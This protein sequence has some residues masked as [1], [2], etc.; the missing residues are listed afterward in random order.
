[1]AGTVVQV[2]EGLVAGIFGGYL[3]IGG[4]IVL[5]P[6]LFLYF[7]GRTGGADS[8]YVALG[9]S[10]AVS[11]FT[12]ASSTLGH[13]FRG[14]W[15]PNA[16]PFLLMGVLVTSYLGPLLAI[17]LHGSV[18]KRLFALLLLAASYQLVRGNPTSQNLAPRN[19]PW[20]LLAIG[21]MAGLVGTLLGVAGGIVMVPLMISLMRFPEKVVAG[22]SSAV[23]I[24]VALLGAGGYIL[25][26]SSATG[27]PQGY[28]GYVHPA[29]VMWLVI[30][31]IPGAQ[32]GAYLNRKWSGKTFRILFAIVLALVALKLVF[33]G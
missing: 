30:G 33:W 10:L 15:R 13:A 5:N 26:G 18:L 22:T 31:S 27:L 11:A 29:T 32:L 8:V 3:G 28:W 25:H 19:S 21:A 9:T 23:G 4:G 12:T 1:L 14:R 7:A 2:L 24:A 17:Q 6:I 16:I 20:L